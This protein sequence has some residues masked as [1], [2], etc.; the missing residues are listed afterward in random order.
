MPLNV[1]KI[2]IAL[3]NTRVT[4]HFNKGTTGITKRWYF[5][6][7]TH[8]HTLLY[9]PVRQRLYWMAKFSSSL[10]FYQI[11]SI[12]ISNLLD[13]NQILLSRI[14]TSQLLPALTTF[15]QTLPFRTVVGRDKTRSFFIQIEEYPLLYQDTDHDQNLES[16][17]NFSF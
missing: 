8:V 12:G 16:I 5:L 11:N 6:F 15:D 4:I 10:Q 17:C 9:I 2:I 14:H 3:I 1:Q 7:K 13:T